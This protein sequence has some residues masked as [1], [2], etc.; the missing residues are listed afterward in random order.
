MSL[1]LAAS[2]ARVSWDVQAGDAG[3]Q[4]PGFQGAQALASGGLSSLVQLWCPPYDSR[5]P[6]TCA[7]GVL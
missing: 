3:G 1:H 4:S 6:R 2:L 7:Y 5:A